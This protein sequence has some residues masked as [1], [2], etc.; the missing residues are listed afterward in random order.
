MRRSK[1]ILFF[2]C[3][4]ISC[5]ELEFRSVQFFASFISI[6]FE[7]LSYLACGEKMNKVASKNSVKL[8]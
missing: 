8:G 5:G 1:K 4:Q 3:K 2:Q 6:S 7:L